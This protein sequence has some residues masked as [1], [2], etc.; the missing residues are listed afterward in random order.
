MDAIQTELAALRDMPVSALRARYQEMFGRPANTT[1]RYFLLH[2]IAWRIQALVSC[3][4]T[5]DAPTSQQ[6]PTQ[7]QKIKSLRATTLPPAPD[8]LPPLRVTSAS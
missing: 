2:R 4:V 3:Q 5:P 8:T 6:A 1:N 7:I